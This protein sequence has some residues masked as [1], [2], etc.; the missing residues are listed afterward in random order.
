ML[1]FLLSNFMI[2]A[3][4]KESAIRLVFIVKSRGES[5]LKEGDKLISSSHGFKSESSRISNPRSSNQLVLLERTLFIPFM[6]GCSPAISALIIKSNILDQSKFMSIPIC[7]RC[8]QSAV[9]DHLNPK[10]S[11]S[12]S[13]FV[14]QLTFF[15]LI[16]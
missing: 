13:S 14:L 7:S 11:L 2:P 10:S 16:E 9:I 1:S 15:L 12:S 3:R 6:I 8:F 4:L 5:A